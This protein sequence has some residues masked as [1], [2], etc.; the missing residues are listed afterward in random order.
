MDFSYT[1][2]NALSGINLTIEPG[3]TVA[4]VGQTGAGKSTLVTLIAR[5][6]DVTSGAV[7]VDGT[8]VR[9]FDL[10]SYRHQ[11]S[12]VPQESY[13]FAGT[14]RDSI[15]YA[16]PDVGDARWRPRPGQPALTT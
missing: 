4:L 6:C 15:A 11:L 3:K 12:V 14:V 1:N 9:D 10:A 2:T 7:L 16:R 8:D 13:P 5:F